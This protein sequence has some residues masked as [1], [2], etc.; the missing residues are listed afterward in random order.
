MVV[1]LFNTA[2]YVFLSEEAMYYCL[3]ILIVSM[4]SYC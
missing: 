1:F 3:R 4:Y 2:I